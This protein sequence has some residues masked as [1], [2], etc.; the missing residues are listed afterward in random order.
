MRKISAESIFTP[1]PSRPCAS[2]QAS[3]CAYYT[4]YAIVLPRIK[5]LGGTVSKSGGFA[6]HFA[7][8]ARL[9][10]VTTNHL[11]DRT[12]KRSPPYGRTTFPG[13]PSVLPRRG[14]HSLRNGRGT[15]AIPQAI[16]PLPTNPV[17]SGP[18][19]PLC[20]QSPL[21]HSDSSSGIMASYLMSQST[22]RRSFWRRALSNRPSS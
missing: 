10:F 22:I 11:P 6:T 21:M 5:D 3:S 2:F 12:E 15:S 4:I 1:P 17:G 7:P 18:A 9:Y 20:G 13:R 14:G 19:Q 16:L 8:F